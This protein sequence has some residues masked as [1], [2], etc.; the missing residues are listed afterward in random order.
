[1]VG[2]AVPLGKAGEIAQC[3]GNF[4]QFPHGEDTAFCRMSHN[5]A[6]LADGA[7]A[8]TAVFEQQRVDGVGLGESVALLL[9]SVA[10]LNLAHHLFGLGTGAEFHRTVDD[11]I[12]FQRSTIGKVHKIL[13]T[14][15]SKRILESQDFW[16]RFQDVRAYTARSPGRGLSDWVRKA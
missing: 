11:F 2:Q 8:R 3:R 16:A 9:R 5:A 6:H 10:R 13:I 1:M 14:P 15:D 12:Q 4:K 7:K